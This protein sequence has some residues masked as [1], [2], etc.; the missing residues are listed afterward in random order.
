MPTYDYECTSC[1]H[2]F[3]KFQ[4]ITEDPVLECPECGEEARRVL[5]GG[6]GVLFKGSGFYSTDYR[7]ESYKKAAEKEKKAD[8]SGSSESTGGTEAKGSSDSSGGGKDSE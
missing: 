3:E 5:S 6:A 2:E 7:S 1:G 8:G 4:K